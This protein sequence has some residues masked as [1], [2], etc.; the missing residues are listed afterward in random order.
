MANNFFKNIVKSEVTRMVAAL[1]LVGML[2]GLVLVFVYQYSMPKI[3]KN[4][5]KA[6]ISSIKN[7]FPKMK[8]VKIIKK[9]KD[10]SKDIIKV[11]DKDG[12]T[13]GYA[14][15]AKGNGYQ[16]TIE[17]VLGTNSDIS[18]LEGFEVLESQETPGLG[19][20]ITGMAFRKQFIG[21]SIT[22]LIEYVKNKKP[23]QPYEIEAITGATISSRAVVNILNRRI[24]KLRKELKSE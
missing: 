6:T 3:K 12:K 7:I 4:L 5:T 14:C 15:A 20:E 22:H 19:A 1:A 9:Y 8:D 2:S 24:T 16:G 21:L 23:D 13:L 17:L 18:N 10:R 11:V